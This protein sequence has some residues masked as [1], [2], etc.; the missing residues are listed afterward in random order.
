MTTFTI[1]G[2]IINT[3]RQALSDLRI[4]AWDKDLFIDDFV[5]ESISD[6]DGFFQIIFTE[7][8]FRELF[9]DRRPDLYFKIFANGKLI[10][11]TENSVLWNIDTAEKEVV[12]IIDRNQGSTTGAPPDQATA[13]NLGKLRS[14]SSLSNLKRVVKDDELDHFFSSSIDQ[15]TMLITQWQQQEKLTEADSEVLTNTIGLLRATR[16]SADVLTAFSKE[17]IHKTSDLIRYNNDTLVN[18]L[19]K[20]SITIPDAQDIESYVDDV[21]A[22]VEAEN[23]SAF[24]MY[25][26][27]EK[28]EWLALDPSLLPTPSSQ[29]RVF[30]ENNQS[31]DLKNEPVIALET[32]EL[33]PQILGISK[34]TPELIRELSSAQQALQLS[35]DSTMAALLLKKEITVKKAATTTRQTL[36]RELNIEAADAVDIKHKA[37]YYHEAAINGYLSYCEI[38]SNPFLKNTL[39]NLAPLREAVAG[40]IGTNSNWNRVKEVNGLKDIDSIEDLFGSQNYCECD[41][42]KSVLSPAAYFVDLMRFTEK[43]VLVQNEGGTDVQLIQDTNPIHLKV[44]RPDLW[45]LELTCDNTNIRI[46]YIEIINEV[47]AAFV[48]KQSGT[49]KTIADRLLQEKPG[50]EFS[51]P[52]NQSLDEVRTW[53]SF[54]ELTRLEVLEYLYPMP[55]VNEKHILAIESLHLSEEQYTIIID[56]NLDAQADTNVLSFRLKS[57]LTAD[58]TD[59]LTEMKFWDGKLSIVQVKDAGDIQQFHIDFSSTLA[60]WQ[61]DLHRLIRLWRLTGWTLNELDL[62]LQAYGINHA[63]LNDAAILNLASFRKIQDCLQL[64]VPVLVGILNG[65]VETSDDTTIRSWKQLLPI[66]WI[67]DEQAHLDDL[68]ANTSDESFNLLMRLQGTFGVSSTDMQACLDLLKD[69]IG[70]PTA[71]NGPINIVFNTNTLNQIYRYVQL[72]KWTGLGSVGA[73]VDLLEVWGKGTVKYFTDLN[74]DIPAF[75]QFLDTFR[76]NKISIDDLIYLFGEELKTLVLV[77]EDKTALTAKEIMDLIASDKFKNGNKFTLLFNKWTSIDLDALSYYKYFIEISDPEL[78]DLFINL[79]GV[80]TEATYIRFSNIRKRLERLDFLTSKYNIDLDTIKILSVEI[81]DC[82]YPK[83]GFGKW[84]DMEWV[85]ELACLGNWID[86]TKTLRNFDLWLTLHTIEKETPLPVAIQKAIAKWKQID[87]TQVSGVVAQT[88]GSIKGIQYLWDRLDWAKKLNINSDQVDKLKTDNSSANLAIQSQVLQNAIRSKF[89]SNETW[90]TQVQDFKNKLSSNQRDALC[91]YVIFNADLR[92]KDFGFEDREDLYRYFLLD[93]SMGDCFTLPRIV[94]A[95]NSLQVYIDRCLLG[96]EQSKDGT[97][98]IVLDID[99]K[100]EWEW[101]KNYRVWEANRKIFLFPENYVEPEIRDNKSPEFKELEDDLLQQKLNSEVVENAYE[102]YIQ[103]IMTLAELKIAGAYHDTENNRIYLFG[104]TNKQPVEYYYRYVDFLENGGT[105]W[106]NWEKMNV[107][108]PAE[109]ISAIRYNGKLYVFWT[110]FQRK[111]ISDVVDGTQDIKM[112]TYDVYTNYSFLQVDKK[113]CAPQKIELDYRTSSPFDPFLRIDKYKKQVISGK[114]PKLTEEGDEIRENALKE[115]ERTVYRKPY[116]SKTQDSN[117]LRLDHIWTDKKHALKAVYKNTRAVFDGFTKTV[118]LKLKMAS[119]GYVPF[120]VEFS[121]NRFDQIVDVASNANQQ[122]APATIKINSQTL[123]ISVGVDKLSFIYSFDSTGKHYTLKTGNSA[124]NSFIFFKDSNNDIGSGDVDLLHRIDY[125]PVDELE[126]RESLIKLAD[127]KMFSSTLPGTDQTVS[128]KQEYN[129]YYDSFTDFFVTNGA[130]DY[131]DGV[132]DYKIQQKD[133]VAILTTPTLPDSNTGYQ[134]N[135]ENIQLLWEKIFMSL[136]DLMDYN[137]QRQVSTQIDYSKSFGNY[138]FELFFHIPMRIAGHLNAAG[139]YSEANQWYSYIYNPTAIKDKFEQLAFPHDV[140]WRFAAF[141]NIGIEKL[142]EIYS[143]PNAIEMYQ[144]NPGNPHAIARLRIG[145]YQKNVVMKYLDNLMDWADSLFEQYTPESTSEARHLYD[146]VK[147]ILGDKPEKTGECKDMKVLTYSDIDVNQNSEF[148]Y[149]LFGVVYKKA[150]NLVISR[151]KST[152]NVSSNG[153]GK[154][155]SLVNESKSVN[156]NK[157]IENFPNQNKIQERSTK[158]QNYFDIDSDLI[159]CFPH[160]EDFMQYWD[161]VNDRIY[162]LN[163]CMDLDGVKKLMPSFAPEIDPALLAR[164]VASGMSFDEIAAAMGEQLPNQRF[165]YLIEKAKQFCATVQSFGSALFGAIEKRDAEELTLLRSR[166]EQNILTLTTKN[167]KRQI[168]QV[169][170]N[171]ANLLESNTNIENRKA[172]YQGLLEE[173]LIEWENVEQIAK[174]TSGSIRAAEGVLQFLSGGLALAPQVGSPFAMK[175]GGVELSSS[176]SKFANALDATA[177][178]ADNVAILAGLEGSHQRREQEWKFLLDTAS[179]ELK[180]MAEQ[181]RASEIAVAIAEFDLELHTTNIDQY[182]ELYDF[183]TTKFTNYK[184]YTFQ[185]QQLQKL[186][187]MAF[188]LANDFAMQAQRA[189]QFERFGTP[190]IGDFIQPD[191]WSS[192]QS[193]LL[194]GERLML[195]LLQLEKEFID[196]DKRKIEITQ[197]FSMLQIAPDKLYALKETGECVGFSIPEAVFDL[198]YPGYFRRIIKSVRVTIPCIAGPY[199]NIGATLTLTGSNIRKDTGIGGLLPFDFYGCAMIATS[200]AQNDGGQFELNFRDERYLPFEGAGAVSTWNL[201]LPKAKQAFDYTTIS[202]VLIHISYTADYDDTF[203]GVVEANLIDALNKI[204]GAGNGFTRVFSLRN[205]FPN[206]WN[207]LS[208]PANNADVILEL[209]AEHFPYFANVDD[210]AGIAPDCFT[211]DASKK[212]VYMPQSNEGITK[213]NSKMKI[214]IPNA[215]GKNYKDVI[216]FVKY[217]VK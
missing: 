6:A 8:R 210:I 136:D 43:R 147:T 76:E 214:R 12:I 183:Y 83:L 35:N 84:E 133:M 113:W 162:K 46:P 95:T 75:V 124:G 121:F 209:K 194:A 93:V 185:V 24:F 166:H 117:L 38:I 65:L 30:Y 7:N 62:I 91:N 203:K 60:N 56:Q 127:Q 16:S 140:N 101:R 31:F 201:S 19:Q 208:L 197:H 135:P 9:F 141:R 27:M 53:L 213:E 130:N 68:L 22:T 119:I 55:G 20:Q 153:S 195:Q 173:G 112:Y 196:T 215:V 165:V 142:K 92:I 164:M 13:K 178:I 150:E 4:E 103:Q 116:P 156:T 114:P 88:I 98:S 154:R 10:D 129:T 144:R 131:A 149:N 118:K 36:M 143:D 163:N 111:D 137:T 146:I 51:L 106:S 97:V 151:K 206:E 29:F 3:T 5:G 170:A 186:Y 52:Y 89:N 108:I 105:L 155:L 161:R 123:T 177:K 104:K 175:Y 122:S 87:L 58:D 1:T 99:E 48:E 79:A 67:T 125:I 102:K 14:L 110:S 61:G 33:N 50:L 207:I 192:D 39:T 211:M 64:E 59:R 148:I 152:S 190:V 2:K 71:P 69:A 17:G 138:F 96:F 200:N 212:L 188:N 18:I 115:F 128:L 132:N 184:H 23:P 107:A 187:R 100:Q 158:P 26:V 217:K 198:S 21:L 57:G 82:V 28:P 94:A 182:K 181:L 15:K 54:F 34:P 45:T 160:N 168:D 159:F 11:S 72:Y 134:L 70:T 171:Y 145:A 216:F 109:D 169:S 202:D 172:H 63:T 90:A 180:G 47:L 174:W 41:S 85:K 73:F 78:D 49:N 191:N 74:E 176:A 199:T 66:D 157:A 139:K 81:Q 32:G 126:Y 204:N 179:Q 205:D 44:R 37:Q 86:E 42:C 80:T 189:F 167:K 120:D 25:R 193:G 40:G 77:E